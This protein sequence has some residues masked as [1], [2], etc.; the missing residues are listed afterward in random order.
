MIIDAVKLR[1]IMLK[2]D[3][4]Q[5]DIAEKTGISRTTINGICRGRACTKESAQKIAD[6]LCIS[7]GEFAKEI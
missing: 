2:H 5:V 3:V 7:V 6:A 4:K 1:T